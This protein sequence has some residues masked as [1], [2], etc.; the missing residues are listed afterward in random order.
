MNWAQLIPSI[1]GAIASILTILLSI[2]ITLAS[3]NF[4]DTKDQL[5]EALDETKN[6]FKESLD[7]MKMEFKAITA[8]LKEIKNSFNVTQTAVAVAAVNL[9]K[10]EAEQKSQEIRFMAE[11][12]KIEKLVMNRP[13]LKGIDCG[14]SE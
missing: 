6:Q 12:N 4:N 8:E 13:C 11:I 14:R 1:V 3:R 2:I 7:E 9:E 10:L 5:K